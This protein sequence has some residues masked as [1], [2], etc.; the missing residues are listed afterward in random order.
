M[1]CF[2]NSRNISTFLTAKFGFMGEKSEVK[3]WFMLI[4]FGLSVFLFR[5]ICIRHCKLRFKV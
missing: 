4:D 2:Q 3:I 5:I 1:I